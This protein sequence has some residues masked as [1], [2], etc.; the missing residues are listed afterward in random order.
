MMAERGAYDRA[1]NPDRVVRRR[2]IGIV[3][4]EI[5]CRI[6][7]GG[8]CQHRARRRQR[9]LEIGRDA[10][11]VAP[12]AGPAHQMPRA[13]LDLAVADIGEAVAGPEWRPLAHQIAD[14]RSCPCCN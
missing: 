6:I 8:R 13:G 3:T 2:L 5:D 7:G 14:E 4:A 11:E 9:M 10:A 1:R 12:P